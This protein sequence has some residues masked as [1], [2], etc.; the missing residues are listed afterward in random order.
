MH[1]LWALRSVGATYTATAPSLPRETPFGECRL[2]WD[3]MECVEIGP[4]CGWLVFHGAGKRLWM[5]SL[6]TTVA[7]WGGRDETEDEHLSRV[8]GLAEHHGVPM[9]GGLFTAF[10]TRRG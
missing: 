6:R 10:K 1:A 9:T 5:R 4:L 2:R 3:E 7:A 8:L